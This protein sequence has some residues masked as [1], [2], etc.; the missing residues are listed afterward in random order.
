MPMLTRGSATPTL[1]WAM[2]EVVDNSIQRAM[3]TKRMFLLRFGAS[4]PVACVEQQHA[5]DED[6]R[7]ASPGR[8]VHGLLFLYRQL[9]RSPLGLVGLLR[10]AEAA[11]HECKHTRC[12]QRERRD[13]D[14]VHGRFS[15]AISACRRG[16]GRRRG[17]CAHTRGF[18]F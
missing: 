7:H 1:T 6:P 10:V 17:A 3:F 11:V 5:T 9:D 18:S 15:S 4:T 12:D 16:R 13:P 8:D 14:G 2:A